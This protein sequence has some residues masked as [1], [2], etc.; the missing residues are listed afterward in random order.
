[1]LISA[2][3]NFWRKK[4]RNSKWKTWKTEVDRKVK[5]RLR[6]DR[7]IEDKTH[8][9]R[10]KNPKGQEAEESIETSQNTKGE[11]TNLVENQ[12]IETQKGRKQK[13]VLRQVENQ[14]RRYKFSRKLEDRNKVE[15]YC[16][17]EV[18]ARKGEKQARTTIEHSIQDRRQKLRRQKSLKPKNW[19]KYKNQKIRRKFFL[20]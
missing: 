11:D 12:K 2:R 19:T 10:Q 7:K 4:I 13:K 15:N 17:G 8:F 18:S 16:Q 20:Q 5:K 3:I 14:R 6:E 1:M 9:R